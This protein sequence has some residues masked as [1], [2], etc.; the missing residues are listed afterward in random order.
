[1]TKNCLIIGVKSSLGIEIEKIFKS[2]KYEVFGTSRSF[3]KKSNLQE[4]FLDF[5]NLESL[6]KLK[7]KIPNIDCLIF[8]SGILLGKELSGY[9]DEEIYK[10][11]QTNIIGPVMTLSR[12]SK[13]LKTKCSIVFIGSI[14]GSAGSYDEIYAS[15]KSA[16]NGLVK[17]LAKKSRNSMRF[18]SIAPGLIENSTMFKKFSAS[19]IENHKKNTPT[20]ELNDLR[21][22]AK[23]CFNICQEEWSQL[24]GQTIDINGGRYV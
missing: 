1:M 21:K 20:N 7:N 15:S 23:I 3:N 11:Y 13:K 9:K 22:I 8:C 16:I 19:E 18:N 17:S 4:I 6:N 2:N 5:E 24:N 14:A 12:I 10:V